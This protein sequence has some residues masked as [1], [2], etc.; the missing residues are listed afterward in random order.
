MV[1]EDV[2]VFFYI[3]LKNK[4]LFFIFYFLFFFIFFTVFGNLNFLG[5]EGLKCFYIVI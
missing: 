4:F 3:G 5:N 1:F 2:F